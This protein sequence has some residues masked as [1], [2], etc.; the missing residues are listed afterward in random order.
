MTERKQVTA[1][2]V[3]AAVRELTARPS[4]AFEA[5][6]A[7]MH[8]ALAEGS[9]PLDVEAP[10]TIEEVDLDRSN[11]QPT[12]EVQPKGSSTYE[13]FPVFE[14]Y[15]DALPARRGPLAVV[16]D[17]VTGEASL[18]ARKSW[19]ADWNQARLRHGHRTFSFTE[20][21]GVAMGPSGVHGEV[22]DLI[23]RVDPET[24][25]TLVALK[26]NLEGSKP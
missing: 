6:W 19:R 13:V 15:T 21:A 1:T 22:P 25:R 9:E 12:I 26:K 23:T 8:A 11:D 2:D 5:T 7:R 18:F 4:P 20:P 17:P 10:P 3:D 24:A 14:V 16:L